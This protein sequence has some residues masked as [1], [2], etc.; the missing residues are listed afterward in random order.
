M[1]IDQNTI[2]LFSQNGY[3]EEYTLDPAETG[4]VLPGSIVVVKSTSATQSDMVNAAVVSS[5]ASA[6]LTAEA[7]DAAK[8]A[9]LNAAEI[10]IVKENALVGGG[11]N[12]P[13]IAGETI[14]LERA[15]SGDRYLLR[16]VVGDYKYG[17]LLY[18]VQTANGIYVTKAIGTGANNAPAVRAVA[19]ENFVVTEGIV[20]L[21]DESNPIGTGK[22]EV[23]N[24]GVVNLLRVRIS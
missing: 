17:D 7:T 13:S 21:K 12:R 3:H 8:A 4:L 14:V 22:N 24:G 10:L 20:D 15:V 18:L 23:P 16:A 6:N 5:Q 19:L 9:V 1:I 11:I 2:T